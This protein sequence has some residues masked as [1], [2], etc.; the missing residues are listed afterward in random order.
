ML[1]TMLALGNTGMVAY[2]FGVLADRLG[3]RGTPVVMGAVTMVTL[4][5]ASSAG[6][7]EAGAP[8]R[9]ATGAR[10]E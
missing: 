4:V 9:V 1:A 8:V 3:E 5:S 7:K 6:R 10:A 2:P